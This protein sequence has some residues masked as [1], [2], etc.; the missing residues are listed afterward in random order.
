M[1]TIPV[2][3]KIH[4]YIL[5][6]PGWSCVKPLKSGLKSVVCFEKGNGVKKI[7]HVFTPKPKES[8]VDVPR[9]ARVRT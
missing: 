7:D 8:D 1:T 2:M 9:Q 5:D 3:H 6:G 4:N